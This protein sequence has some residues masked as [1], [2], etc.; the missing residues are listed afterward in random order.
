[1]TTCCF[2]SWCY[3]YP[4]CSMIFILNHPPTLNRAQCGCLRPRYFASIYSYTWAESNLL[5]I[6]GLYPPPPLLL[7]I[8]F[9][10]WFCKECKIS[11]LLRG[12][13]MSSETAAAAEA[14]LT[15]ASFL[16]VRRPVHIWSTYVSWILGTK[17]QNKEKLIMYWSAAWIEQLF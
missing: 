5:V 13:E 2:K 15:A 4:H 6:S 16:L 3:S 1:M 9:E 12:C 8:G 11:C 14:V 17:R 10:T 7:I